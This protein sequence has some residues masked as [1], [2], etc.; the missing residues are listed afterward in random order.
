[1]YSSTNVAKLINYVMYDGKKSTAQKIVYGA[2]DIIK[3][4]TK[5]E[6]LEVFETAL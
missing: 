4:K 3:D 1:M 2:F 5:K 6:P